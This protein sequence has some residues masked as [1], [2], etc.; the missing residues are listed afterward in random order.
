MSH[1]LVLLSGPLGLEVRYEFSKRVS[2]WGYHEDISFH[3]IV[4]S[5]S[6]VGG[7]IQMTEPNNVRAGCYWLLT[8]L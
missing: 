8:P 6:I 4:N 3:T 5:Y 7:V 1:H 2:V